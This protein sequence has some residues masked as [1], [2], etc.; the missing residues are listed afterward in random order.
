[1]ARILVVD[2]DP[3]IRRLVHDVLTLEGYEVE[4]AEDG[5]VALRILEAR[6]PDA[7]VL[8]L[9]LPGLDGHELLR[10]I[11]D[12]PGPRL[13]VVM[14]TAVDAADAAAQARDSGADAF[15]GKPFEPVDLLDW[16][17]RLLAGPAGAAGVPG[18]TGPPC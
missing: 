4:Q 11:R 1:M 16:L 15:L 17:E 10:R 3:T 7:V 18:P 8:D 13:P 5:F 12:A 14:L 6:R 9:M 2:D